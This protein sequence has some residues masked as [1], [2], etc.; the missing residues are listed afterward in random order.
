M[1]IA[2]RDPVRL[3]SLLVLAMIQDLLDQST[4]ANGSKCIQD[5]GDLL[6]HLIQSNLI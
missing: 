1:F 6:L 4:V 5:G 2:F 3:D